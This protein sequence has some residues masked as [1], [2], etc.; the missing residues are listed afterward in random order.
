[1]ADEQIETGN[2]GQTTGGPGTQVQEVGNTGQSAGNQGQDILDNYS[3]N[4]SP[5]GDVG[6]AGAQ[7]RH[8]DADRM[9][10]SESRSGGTS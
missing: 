5:L 1:M 10:S 6:D 3:E 7:Q 9:G 4:Q 8:S 2:E